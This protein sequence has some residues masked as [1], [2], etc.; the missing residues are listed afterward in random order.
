MQNM[1]CYF[2]ANIK[3]H[4]EVEY[5]KYLASCD[6]I[7]SKYNGKYIAVDEK[8]E[9]LEGKFDY[10]KIVIVYF[11]NKADFYEWYNSKEYNEIK[12]YR[13]A[14]SDCDTILVNGK[15]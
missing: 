15:K 13:L 4:D 10:S 8:P 7:F 1:G 3:I 9:I 14:G 6:A 2:V 11:K 5:D 12:K